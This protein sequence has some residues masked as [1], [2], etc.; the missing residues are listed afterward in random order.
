MPA[1]IETFDLS[2]SYGPRRVLDRVTLSIDEGEHVVL[3]GLNGAGKSTLLRVLAGLSRPTAG[4]VAVAGQA[5][6]EQGEQARLAIGLLAHQSGLYADLT[7]EQNLTF[8]ARLYGLP[9]VAGT[10]ADWLAR[11]GLAGRRHDRVGTFSCGMARRLAL[12]RTLLHGPRALLL[13]EPY[14]GLDVRAAALLDELLDKATA[15][16]CTVLLATHRPAQDL[17]AGRRVLALARGRL[18]YD[19]EAEG[20]QERALG[21]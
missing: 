5:P 11:V 12:A 13:D 14:A 2:K 16:G 21:A 1:M 18:A 17:P 10:V 6:G 8:F 4:R 15:R 7:A 19:G 9:D 20:F 3:V